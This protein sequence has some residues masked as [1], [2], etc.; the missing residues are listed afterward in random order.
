MIA[1]EYQLDDLGRR[2]GPTASMQALNLVE[3]VSARDQTDVFCAFGRVSEANLVVLVS[4]HDHLANARGTLRSAA[5]FATLL[6]GL[7]RPPLPDG[8]E[9]ERADDLD[10]LVELAIRAQEA[11][12]LEPVTDG[13]LRD[14]GLEA[15]AA[16][17][18]SSESAGPITVE[19]WRFAAALTDRAVKQTLPGPYTLGSTG[20]ERASDRERRTMAAA[21]GLRREVEALAA[22]GCPL[23][24]IEELEAN[25]IGDDDVERRLFRKAH[26]RL[27]DGI[28]GT[29]LSLSIVGGSAAGAGV[30]TVLDAPYASLA[31][32]LIAGP[33]N[34]N[35][36]TRAPSDRGVVAGALSARDVDEPKEVLLWAAHYAASTAGRGLARV[37]IGSAGD[38]ANLTWEAA[39]RKMRLLGEAARLAELPPGE[40][41]AQSVDSASI[42]ARRA[43][44]GRAAARNAARP[45]RR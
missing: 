6:G 31:V 38:Y 35:L 11:A 30:E 40:K 21:E 2:C 18:G 33:D 1:Y 10:V 34:W 8:H 3:R 42:S 4:G 32:D 26:R 17:L 28:T 12:G 5:M 9:I 7:P 14:P 39:V 23:I 27:T 19:G 20:H 16:A 37:G 43:G 41:L 13:R 45:P 22:A 15:L 25:L 24:E 36:V 44:L 29:H